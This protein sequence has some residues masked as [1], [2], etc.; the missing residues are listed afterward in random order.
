MV[1]RLSAFDVGSP[2]LRLVHSISLTDPAWTFVLQES[3]SYS[4]QG[5]QK[6]DN[7]AVHA[8]GSQLCQANLDPVVPTLH[9][10]PSF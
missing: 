2:Q 1:T 5:L 10:A 9:R 6:A 7:P 3:E 4:K 8:A